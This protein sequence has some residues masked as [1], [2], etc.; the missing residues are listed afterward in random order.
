MAESILAENGEDGTNSW[1]VGAGGQAGDSNRD[2]DPSDKQLS[3]PCPFS[4]H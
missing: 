2:D 3:T 1:G 4:F